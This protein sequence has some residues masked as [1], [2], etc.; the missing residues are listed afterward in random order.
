MILK[1]SENLIININQISHFY[2]DTLFLIDGSKFK[3][4]EISVRNLNKISKI[5][6]DNFFKGEK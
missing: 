1:I 6:E 5:N 3:L 4:D 2:N